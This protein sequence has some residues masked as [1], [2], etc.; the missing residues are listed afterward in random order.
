MKKMLRWLGYN[1]K[2]F[3]FGMVMF[4][5]V[6]MPYSVTAQTTTAC[7]PDYY[8][9]LESRAWMEAQR[10]IEQNQNLIVKPD[11]VLEYTCFDLFG[12]ELAEHAKDMFSETTRWGSILPATSM[13]NALGSLVGSSLV[14][15]QT[16]NFEHKSL[17]GRGVDKHKFKAAIRGGTYT[18]DQMNK[19]WQ[20]SDKSAKCYNF[21]TLT[22]Q[23]NFF[24]FK[25]F[26]KKDSKGKT[27]RQ[28]PQA[29]EP[30][31]R[32]A[33]ENKRA[34][35]KYIGATDGDTPWQEDREF[36]FLD[37]TA[38][39]TKSPKVKTGIKVTISKDESFD[40]IICV[41]PGCWYDGKGNCIPPSDSSGGP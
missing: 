27:V 20:T 12:A 35:G 37:V 10:E 34:L 5:A 25:Q 24:T 23:D 22:E 16:A 39:C 41:I 8:K 19:I 29:C 3:S 7:D 9:S 31:A 15:Y 14:A 30:D 40:E 36:K 18:C 1:P 26:E 11:S 32:W 28:L 33:D 21:Q 38:E 13:D 4:F 6:L 2:V 17:G